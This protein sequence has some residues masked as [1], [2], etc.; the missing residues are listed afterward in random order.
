M[1]IKKNIN[2]FKLKVYY[3]DTDAGGIVYYAN[4]LKYLE[5]ARTELIKNLGYSNTYLKEKFNLFLV[6]KACNINFNAPARLEELLIIETGIKK[7]SK[8]QL[9]L[10]QNIFRKEEKILTAE[11]RIAVI[12]KFGKISYLPNEFLTLLKRI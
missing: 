3:E 5:R 1:I 6:V 9:Y 2:K 11:I 12:N 7:V 4:Y 10:N 8:I